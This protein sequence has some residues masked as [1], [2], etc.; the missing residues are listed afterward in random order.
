MSKS[1]E[2]TG[3]YPQARRYGARLLKL[4]P[5]HEY[6]HRQMMRLM[7]HSGEFSAALRQ[8]EQCR[9]ILANELDIGPSIATTTLYER[10][11]V[12]M[13]LPAH[14]LPPQATAFI[15]REEEA[16]T[17]ID[18]LVDPDCRLLTLIGVGGIGKSRLAVEV[19][20]RM[21]TEDF[22]PFLHGIAF[23]PLAGVER[24]DLIAAIG[25][26][27]GIALNGQQ[28]VERQ[29][30]SYLRDMD[31]LLLL[32]NYEHLL[33]ETSLLAAILREAPAVKV[34][35]TSRERLNLQEE[36]LFEVDGL[37]YPLE[38]QVNLSEVDL[39]EHAALHLFITCAQRVQRTISLATSG[40]EVTAICH[41]VQGM[42]LALELAAARLRNLTPEKVLEELERGLDILTAETRNASRRHA[43]LRAAFDISWVGLSAQE[44]KALSQLS[45][46]RSG[47][48]RRTASEVAGATLPVLNRL[49]NKSLIRLMPSGRYEM[50]ELIRQYAAEK[51][52][53]DPVFE[54]TIREEYIRYYGTFLHQ[55]EQKLMETDQVET[56]REIT[57]ELDNIRQ[58]WR[59]AVERNHL[60]FLDQS[61][62]TVAFFYE[63]RGWYPEALDQ[64]ERT[65]KKLP[66][67]TAA[68]FSYSRIWIRLNLFHSYF[69]FRI[70]RPIESQTILEKISLQLHDLGDDR[71]L[72]W[73]KFTMGHV[74]ADL[75]DVKG[76]I[77]ALEEG[78]DICRM[79]GLVWLEAFLVAR[80]AFFLA[81]VSD[82]DRQIQ[83]KV[84]Q[85]EKYA[86]DIGR[87][88]DNPWVQN[89]VNISC[90]RLAVYRGEYDASE[91]LDQRALA[92]A[93]RIENLWGIGVALF[94]LGLD[95]YL[96]GDTEASWEYYE[97]GRQIIHRSGDMQLEAVL[98]SA[99][100]ELARFQEDFGK[101]CQ[102]YQ[103]GIEIC[104]E[105]R[106]TNL[107]AT[108]YCMYGH[109]LLRQAKWQQA[110]SYFH[111]SISMP[112]SRTGPTGDMTGLNLLG[113]AG[114]LGL[115]IKTICRR[116][117]FG[118]G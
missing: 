102:C 35:V 47:F 32:D 17:I 104:K 89:I 34:L 21:G 48:T 114:V 108:V 9:T 87:Q 31:L 62:W 99:M 28:P 77:T 44:R 76:A 59:W 13:S 115:L 6:G 63:L 14:N 81:R 82:G 43:S 33:P 58:A 83:A 12:A 85:L 113:F 103:Q 19:A 66:L 69:L 29:L 42:P 15:G 118:C 40:S 27:L 94:Y 18:S 79:A 105:Y 5:W 110:W 107:A 36:W 86:L 97:E 95:K 7:A 101:A 98:V 20:Q 116:A 93:R 90:S 56:L 4:A 51:L 78:V 88:L 57:P 61:L 8:Y 45:L 41:L 2:R 3:N 74:L 96:Q 67:L 54:D 92:A 106:F 30:L 49:S 46:F 26:G 117:T 91:L 80:T 1:E 37:P 38:G 22:R 11:K 111:R 25:T 100:G 52:A 50:H 65:L 109:A 53:E 24:Q 39:S 70:G 71:D 112:G 84:R 68:N 10:I 64:M 16:A 72:A 60:T 73:A 55:R 23:V 75:D